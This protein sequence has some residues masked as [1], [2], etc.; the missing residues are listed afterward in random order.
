LTDVVTMAELAQRVD[1]LMVDH[2]AVVV[3]GLAALPAPVV[4]DHTFL[5]YGLATEV[6]RFFF[7]NQWTNENIFSIHPEV[8]A[9]HRH[10]RRFFRTDLT[11]P[12][13]QFRHMQRVAT[14]AEITFNLQ[15]AEGLRQRISLM[16]KHDLESALGELECAALL[17]HSELRLRFVTPTGSRGVDYEAEITTSAERTVCCEIKVKSESTSLDAQTLWSALEKAR[18]QLPKNRPGLVLV[19]IPEDWPKR[20]DT[21]AVVREAVGKV[22]RQSQR[23]VGAI[24]LWE[25]WH[26]IPEGWNFVVSR[27][28]FY[29][30]RNSRLYQSDID[31][32]LTVI[33]RANDPSWISFHAF[34]EQTRPTS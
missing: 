18:K 30:N 29:P 27:F 23:L 21:Q 28:K 2:L 1:R 9:H 10:G 12:E 22:F 17:A 15:N 26:R 34:V 32:L 4:V 31:D 19:K 3:R 8:S 33:G 5:T 20:P 25:E 7:G 24:V 14:L 16:D 6:L 13:D 11:D